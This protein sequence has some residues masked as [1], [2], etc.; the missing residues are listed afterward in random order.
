VL[1]SPEVSSDIVTTLRGAGCVYAEDEAR[2][3]MAAAR[4]PAELAGMVDRRTSG[5][6][7]EQIL[8]WAEFCGLRVAVD[9]GVFIPRRRTEFLV[10]RVVDLAHQAS[11]P[12]PVVVDLC[13][14]SGAVGVA[15]L[16]AL[17]DIELS[18]SDIDPVAT[19]C[20]RRNLAGRGQVYD[21]DL[22]EPL[23]ATLRGRVDLLV[24]NAPYVPTADIELLPSEARLHEPR[25]ALDGGAD[26]LDIA[27]RVISAAGDWL[28]P[29]GHVVVETSTLQAP[30]LM[31]TATRC[32]LTAHVSS[33]EEG[34]ATVVSA[35]QGTSTIFPRVWRRSSSV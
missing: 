15:L 9:P 1:P 6:P 26:G 28:A 11:R 23:P 32:G 25:S 5:L 21:G 31:D 34:E 17:G 35:R 8:G 2:L 18:A 20:A 30:Q 12:R 22:Y 14:G 3:L 33:S 16:A 19:Q 13:C 7:L 27:R 4:T 29:G 10:Q 24:A